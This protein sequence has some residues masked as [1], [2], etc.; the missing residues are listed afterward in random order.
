[1]EN[2]T[3]KVDNIEVFVEVATLGVLKEAFGISEAPPHG[4]HVVLQDD[5][6]LGMTIVA[7]LQMEVDQ[8]EPVGSP[9]AKD[10]EMYSSLFSL[11][12]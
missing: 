3:F 6:N 12:P 10:A 9:R 5:G 11:L 7:P 1:M 2:I 4:E 8:D